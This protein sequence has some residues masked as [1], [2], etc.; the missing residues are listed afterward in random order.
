MRIPLHQGNETLYF[1]CFDN[2]LSKNVSVEILQGNTY[3]P[4]AHITDIQ[5]VLDIGANIGASAVY[6][7]ST[8]QNAQIFAFEPARDPF[9]L[10]QRNAKL[11]SR[12]SPYIFGMFSA[13]REVPLYKGGMDSVTGSVGDSAETGADSET[14]VLRSIRDWLTENAISAIDILKVDTE[15]CELPILNSLTDLL[16]AIKILHLEYHS[17]S[18]RREMDRLLGETHILAGG[19]ILQPH[20]AELTYIGNAT[21]DDP[22]NRDRFEI[23]VDL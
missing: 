4:A 17:E 2:A 6:F 23:K 8:C 15:G 7:A 18:D 11:S 5:V 10:L 9:Q 20:R 12:I 21:Y 16:P 19:K 13:D 1:E 22:R 14:V 3:K